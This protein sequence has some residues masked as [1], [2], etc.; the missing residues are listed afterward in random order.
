MPETIP[1]LQ[2]ALQ[3]IL[4]VTTKILTEKQNMQILTNSIQLMDPQECLPFA[5]QSESGK[6]PILF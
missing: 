5:I 3:Q 6:M 1:P 4:L 2:N